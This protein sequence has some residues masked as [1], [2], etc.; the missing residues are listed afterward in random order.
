MSDAMAAQVLAG[1]IFFGFVY[2]VMYIPLRNKKLGIETPHLLYRVKRDLK[3]LGEKIKG[4]F[5]LF[6]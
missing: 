1:L 6:K 4:A 5:N 3:A 2:Y